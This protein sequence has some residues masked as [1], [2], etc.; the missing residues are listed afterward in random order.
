MALPLPTTRRI[1]PSS[2]WVVLYSKCCWHHP[3]LLLLLLLHIVPHP[4]RLCSVFFF[5]VF[6]PLYINDEKVVLPSI[7]KQTFKYQHEVL[8]RFCFEHPYFVFIF[9]KHSVPLDSVHSLNVLKFFVWWTYKICRNFSIQTL[10]FWTISVEFCV[11]KIDEYSNWQKFVKFKS[12][13]FR[14]NRKA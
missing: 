1:H 11:L 14:L 6:M 7:A 2:A 12:S 10:L 4:Y 5:V 13:Y 3:K 9:N 8:Q